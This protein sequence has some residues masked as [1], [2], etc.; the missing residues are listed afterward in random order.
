VTAA[1]PR[2]ALLDYG[3]GNLHSAAKALE[4]VGFDVRW[5]T[6]S[7]DVD[8]DLC[9]VPGVGH[10]RRCREALAT[11]GLD[12]PVRGWVADG[13][14]LLGICVG[15]QLLFDGSDEA[16]G[17]AGLGLVPGRVERLDA[18]RLPHMGWSEVRPGP[19]SDGL[20]P[21][22][23]RFYFVHSYGLRPAD[24]SAVA[25]QCDYGGGFAAAV[26]CGPIVATQFHPE[27][28]GRAG[29]ELLARVRARVATAA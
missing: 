18:E 24:A 8:G 20:F 6:D 15:A 9:V 28:S 2:A 19:A 5:V 3:M 17:C 27:K 10:F 26:A 4:R 22:T 23:T 16:D 12:A 11:A 14:P 1:R 7:S 25:G 29:L 21:D 13:R